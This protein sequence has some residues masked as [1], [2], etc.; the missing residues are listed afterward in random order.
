MIHAARVWLLLT[1]GLL[2]SACANARLQSPQPTRE[3]NLLAMADW[4]MLNQNQKAVAAGMARYV[5]QGNRD[6]D[7]LL[8][9]GDNIYICLLYT[10]PSPR[11]S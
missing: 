10:S 3:V 9:G 11:D 7:G 1:L 5:S 2:C 4:G 8:T 6:Y